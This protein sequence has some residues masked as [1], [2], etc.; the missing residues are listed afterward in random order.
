[1]SETARA[2]LDQHLA[3]FVD[4]PSTIAWPNRV[5]DPAKVTAYWK[6]SLLLVG[7]NPEQGS[8]NDHVQ[9]IYQVS[10]MSPPD[11]GIAQALKDCEALAQHF[12][13]ARLGDVQCGR[14][15]IGTPMSQPDRL[16]TPVSIP[17]L[18]L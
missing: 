5:F 17:F 8:E 16:H 11:S 9:G 18:C 14:P 6:V 1:M 10:R 7:I 4:D 3:A 12:R 2:A 15:T 13:L